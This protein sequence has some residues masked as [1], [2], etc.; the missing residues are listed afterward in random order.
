VVLRNPE[1]PVAHTLN[2]TFMCENS[3]GVPIGGW[4]T[5]GLAPYTFVW[6]PNNGSLSGVNFQNPLANPDTTTT[7]YLQV[8]DAAGCRSQ[9][10]PQQVIVYPLPIVDAGPDL[11]Y[12]KDGPAI[13]LN[14]QVTN[15]Y[16][17]YE[18]QWHPAS[19]VYCD[20]CLTTYATPDTTTIFTVWVRS[21]TTGCRSINTTLNTVSSAVIHVKPRPIA[22]A[23]PD[24]TICD[25][26]VAT[27]CAVA[28]GAGPN[29]SYKWSP[30]QTLVN[31]A[32]QCAVASP[33]HTMEYYLVATSEG[34][35]SIADTVRVNVTTLP[36]TDAGNVKNICAGDSVKL[37]GQVQIGMAQQFEWSP[38][39]GLNASTLMQPNAS[40]SSTVWYS[41]RGY[42]A[43][44]AGPWDSVQVIVHSVPRAEAGLDTTI[45]GGGE[46]YLQ[47]NYIGGI[48]P[49]QIQWT[50]GTGLPVTNIL[51]PTAKPLVSTL[52]YLS[53]QSG[54]GSTICRTV[55]SVMVTVLPGVFASLSAD[56]TKLCPGVSVNLEATGGVGSATYTWFP[57][58]GLSGTRNEMNAS[59]TTTTLYSV[60]ISEGLCRDTASVLL[61]VHPEP[62]AGF[63]MSQPEGCGQVEV[64]FNDLSSNTLGY[65]WDFADG[66]AYNNERNPSHTYTKS[67][68]FPVSLVVQGVGGCRDTLVSE[69]EINLREGLKADALS[70]PSAPVEL[71]APANEI[72]WEDKTVGA[73]KWVWSFGDGNFAHTKTA[74]H[75]YERPGT[76]FVELEVSDESGCRDMLKMGPYVVKEENL[77]IPN[78][79]SPNGDGLN[80]LFRIAYDGDEL[81]HLQIFDRWGVKYY[82]TRNREQAW[83]GKD[84]NGS[85]A[86]EGVYFYT[87]I[88]GTRKYSSNVT[89]IR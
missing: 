60:E 10:E 26:S 76:Y 27:L 23:G 29:Y 56:T 77:N 38:I 25:G 17:M 35:E 5:G 82:D 11:N 66:S 15:P 44:C 69:L 36:V 14:A 67:G 34:C 31:D 73:T 43:G 24:T 57:T 52:Y 75:R 68:K 30:S 51:N 47:G 61:E 39:A 4:G 9:L 80:D 89:L 50:P 84:L 18:V 13:F 62:K 42:N 32:V 12:C 72:R 55:D 83:D 22:D 41:L 64:K 16:G 37:D 2:D 19:G 33:P 7:Y 79:F 1:L 74:L 54:T 78:V 87:V 8:V 20:T 21:R 28:T 65:I 81:F 40:P 58:T 70:D 88:I 6:L 49:V 3:G 48:Q 53:A 71:F 45:C 63:T 59:P 86:A 46:A 85:E